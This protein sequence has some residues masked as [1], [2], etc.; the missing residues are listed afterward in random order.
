[1][2]LLWIF[3]GLAVIAALT[4]R[5]RRA[6]ALVDRMLLEERVGAEHDARMAEHA[7]GLEVE[8]APERTV[9]WPHP[10]RLAWS[11]PRPRAGAH[12]RLAG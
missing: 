10:P 4:W 2:T 1:M 9:D 3:G 11:R 8:Q 5:L 12:N 6:S 7:R